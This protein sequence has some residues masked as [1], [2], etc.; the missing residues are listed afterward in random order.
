MVSCGGE[1]HQSSNT[2][3]MTKWGKQRESDG[4]R[5]VTGTCTI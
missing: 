2:V 4:N 5:V 3:I 1:S